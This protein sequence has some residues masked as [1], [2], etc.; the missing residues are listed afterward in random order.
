MSKDRY[1]LRREK[2]KSPVFLPLRIRNLE[3]KYFSGVLFVF[4]D[5]GFLCLLVNWTGLTG[6]FDVSIEFEEFLFGCVDEK[7]GLVVLTVDW[8][9]L[10]LDFGV[11]RIGDI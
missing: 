2:K 5:L 4:L 11:S 6:C 8:R 1:P 10:K 3:E 7:I 9:E